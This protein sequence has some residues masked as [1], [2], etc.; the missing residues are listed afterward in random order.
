MV[1]KFVKNG[2]NGQNGKKW[3][4]M[5]K[6]GHNDLKW[7]AWPWVRPT[8]RPKRPKTEKD[9]VKR[10]PTGSQ[11]PKGLHTSL[12]LNSW[13]KFWQLNSQTIRTFSALT[14]NCVRYFIKITKFLVRVSSSKA[15][16][17]L[18]GGDLPDLN[19]R[20]QNHKYKTIKESCIF[21]WSKCSKKGFPVNTLTLKGFGL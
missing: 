4:K 1:I 12:S 8:Y 17:F 2:Q 11:G 9:V 5:V 10:P 18:G 15:L 3:F 21:G 6:I 14:H 20:H 16:P 19:S 7:Q 13:I